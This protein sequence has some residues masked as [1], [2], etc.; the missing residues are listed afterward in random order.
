MKRRSLNWVVVLVGFGLAGVVAVSGAT[1]LAA[2]SAAS[3]FELVLQGRDEGFVKGD[4]LR[5]GRLV[6]TF[7]SGAP[8]CESGTAVDV[9]LPREHGGGRARRYTMRR[10]QRQL[11]AS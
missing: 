10:W 1:A 3:P 9:E 8:F 2:R 4:A 7:T 11:D 6:A 5:D